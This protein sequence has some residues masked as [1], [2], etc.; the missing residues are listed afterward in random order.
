MPFRCKKCPGGCAGFDSPWV[1]NCG[2]AWSSHT[3]SSVV[4]FA[5]DAP[6]A[7]LQDVYRAGV[8]TFAVRQDG[9]LAREL[10]ADMARLVDDEE[11]N[12][13]HSGGSHSI[14]ASESV[15]KY[16]IAMNGGSVGGGRCNDSVVADK[17]GRNS[18]GARVCIRKPGTGGAEKG[19]T[20]VITE[21]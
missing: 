17:V 10:E 18:S 14:I 5:G 9:L 19:V 1:C 8:R 15:G 12:S 13:R 20:V 7:Q 11:E 2:H 6:D 4:R 16:D 3:Q 21:S